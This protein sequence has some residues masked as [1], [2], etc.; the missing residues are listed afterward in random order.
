[1]E[2]ELVLSK[3]NE[4]LN[5]IK[6][7]AGEVGIQP[8]LDAEENV[9]TFEASVLENRLNQMNNLMTL[10]QALG[11]GGDGAAIQISK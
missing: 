7:R 2:H 10:Y 5:E 8:W 11:G 4:Q 9:R 3:E 1:M 6:Y